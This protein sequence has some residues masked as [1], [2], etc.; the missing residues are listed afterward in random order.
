MSA[1][2]VGACVAGTAQAA[3]A[4]S[5]SAGTGCTDTWTGGGPK[6]L[7]NIAQNWSTGKV[8]GPTSDVCLSAFV[9]VTANGPVGIHSLHLGEESTVIFSGTA[10]RP[11]HVTIA[12][13]VDNQGNVELDNSSLTAPQVNNAGGLA[14]QGTSV[15]T[16]P[17][18]HNGGTVDAV[19]GSLILPDSL[20]QL[21]NG[22]L[23]GG[24]WLALDNG[25]LMLPGDITTLAS[26]LVSIGAGSA[27]QDQAGHN[28]LAG[29]TSVAPQATLAVGDSLT[30]S[31]SLISE[32]TLEIGSYASG[33]TLTVAGTLT[34]AH[35]VM[36]M[37][38]QST[39]TAATVH[40]D[41][42]SLSASGTID[43]NLVNDG[44]VEPASRLAVTGS[45]RQGAVGALAAGFGP[46]LQ[47]AGKATLA[48]ALTAGAAPPPAP[49]TRGTAITF[50]SLSGGFT[51]H[52][53]GF[54]VVTLAHQ[55]DVTAQTQLA[56]SP[57]TV[58]RGATATMTGGDFGYRDT[59]TLFLDQANGRVLG[60]AQAGFQGEF[61]TGITI[62][63]I[64]PGTHTIIA[65]G[66]S[67]RQAQ[68]IITVT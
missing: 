30:L 40:I 50:R 15:L 67:G 13:T 53:L 51:T 11:S 34:E 45:Y 20:A 57:A 31:G 46:E 58:A 4:I 63:W 39:V 8:P 14:A 22:T 49:G 27:I 26:G 54:T 66:S 65:V 10:G 9:F 62:P 29:L 38:S 41:H 42:G 36:T 43:G 17:A 1:V 64:P 61:S 55:I 6:V 5:G 47:V 19:T 68:T 48:G 59:V 37:T 32:G 25:V 23:A 21:S 33:G 44:L 12:T 56:A 60:T 28:A 2:T 7:W 35:N 52:N 3:A 18:F 24:S 16:S